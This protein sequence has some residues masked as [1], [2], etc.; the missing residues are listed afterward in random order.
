[1]ATKL[2]NQ[3]TGA[4]LHPNAIDGTTGTELS[5][6]SQAAYDGRYARTTGATI[7]PTSNSTTTLKVT[8]QDG[9]TQVFDIDTTNARVGIGTAT[10]A[11]GLEISGA[12][13]ASTAVKAAS[14]ITFG[15]GWHGSSVG[16]HSDGTNIFFGINNGTFFI[17]PQGSGSSTNSSIF[18]ANGNLAVNA[19]SAT[20]RLTVN[21]P[22]ATAIIAS[23]KTSAY[24]AGTSDSTIL[25]DGTSAAFQITLPT[26]VGCQGR[27]YTIKRANSGANNIT[28]GTTASQTIDGTATKTL[29][30]QY[31]VVT[32]QSDNAN[33]QI[34]STLG[35][36]S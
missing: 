12:S 5:V 26:A 22:I 23:P 32:V 36:V 16:M 31:A 9:T 19:T 3:M 34:L 33:W 28:V 30:S 29:G 25:A 35:T 7:T 18:D 27:Q 1:M 17:R 14:G 13:G 11:Y 15:N 10:P 24:T 21:G 4:D 20:S 2:H 8:K 6:A